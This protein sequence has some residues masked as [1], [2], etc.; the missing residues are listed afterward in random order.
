[1]SNAPET[2]EIDRERILRLLF[3]V[4]EVL[5]YTKDDRSEAFCAWIDE[6]ITDVYNLRLELRDETLGP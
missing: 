5:P 3:S 4:Q 1:M 6:I 2:V